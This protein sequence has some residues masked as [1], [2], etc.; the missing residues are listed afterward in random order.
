ML[1]GLWIEH[2]TD[3]KT[4]IDWIPIKEYE[5]VAQV[6]REIK[7]DTQLAIPINT[8]ITLH[9]P[10]GA[11]ISPTEPISAL[12]PGTSPESPLRV[13]VS[14]L[15]LVT[16]KPASCVELARFWSSLRDISK[17]DEFLHFHRRP[18]FFPER[19][20]SLY[21][22]KAYEDL[23]RIIWENF[24]HENTEKR[25][26]RMAITGTPGTGKS[27]FLFYI[28]WRL[29]N[30]GNTRTVILHRQIERGGIY[31][32]QNS[33]CW[34]T[35]NY[36]DIVHLLRD[37][38]TWYLTDSLEPPP[39]L[40]DAVTILVSSPAQKYYS[41]FLKYLPIPPLHY[42]PTW[43]LEE[44]KRVAHVYLKSLEEVEKRFD[45]VGGIARYVLEEDEDLEAPINEAI[46]IQLSHIPMAIPLA[47]GSRENEI[48]HRLV[49]FRVKS[50]CY[51]KYKLVMASKYIRKK[52]LEI[53]HDRPEEEL[54]YYLLLLFE[55]LPFAIFAVGRL[56]EHYAHRQLSTTGVFS[57]RVLD[58][59]C[60][61][62]IDFLPKRP[63]LFE[64]FSECRDS[65]V[66]YIARVKNDACINS[67]IL[68]IGYF[69]MTIL[70]EPKV[71]RNQMKE[72]ENTM[73]MGRFYFVV[74]H[75]IYSEFRKQKLLEETK[76]NNNAVGGETITEE[77]SF[78]ENE[79]SNWSKKR[80]K[81]KKVNNSQTLQK[82]LM[83]QEVI[84]IPVDNEM[85]GWLNKIKQQIQAVREDGEEED[86]D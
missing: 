30:M 51:T 65:G 57:R 63:Q 32:F 33:G 10:S 28:L 20:K 69:R 61:M 3:A 39:A 2:E 27:I 42:L 79:D 13:Q 77:E 37:A 38:T 15:P 34:E 60:E 53:L 12:I 59:G 6:I 74:P 46:E 44:L 41:N 84:G 26:C 62:L 49:H 40:V 25:L 14:P 7:Q 43:S 4:Y 80:M 29:A 81:I 73:K 19:M 70:L 50:P 18:K 56:F 52:F 47:D 17:T 22:R 58:R 45:M 86:M 75:T 5:F 67:H 64:K 48:N 21:V 9:G 78:K 76:S 83:G 54:K 8:E 1:Q 85:A 31:V 66:Y 71:T 82:E 72:L 35:F 24:Q 55:D 16:I 68:G 11:A 36:S 23:F